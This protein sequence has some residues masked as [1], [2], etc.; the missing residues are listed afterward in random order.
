MRI[1]QHNRAGDRGGRHAHC[2]AYGDTYICSGNGNTNPATGV[3]NADSGATHSHPHTDANAY[4]AADADPYAVAN[5]DAHADPA[6]TH[7]DTSATDA[8]GYTGAD[9][10]TDGNFYPD[11]YEYATGRIGSHAD[12]NSNA[13]TAALRP[14]AH[15]CAGDADGNGYADSY[16]DP[17]SCFGPNT[18]SVARTKMR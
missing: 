10:Y 12:S 4:A 15:I 17:Y 5:A 11:T 1:K 7:S 9:P 2:H 13:Y 6:N 16:A 18:Y 3:G 8:D 14:A